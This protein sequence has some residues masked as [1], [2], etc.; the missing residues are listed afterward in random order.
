[1]NGTLSLRGYAILGYV[2]SGQRVSVES[3]QRGSERYPVALS[4]WLLDGQGVGRRAFMMR[5]RQRVM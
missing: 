1:V 4:P 2:E 3:G 5:S